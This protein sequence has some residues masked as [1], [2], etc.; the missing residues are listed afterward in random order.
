M[1]QR[2]Y[3]QLYRELRARLTSLG[4]DN[5]ENEARWLLEHI[6]GRPFL[7]LL[8]SEVDAAI[9]V[10]CDDMVRELAGG[11]PFQYV[12]GSQS[13]Y[14]LDL[15]VDERVLIPRRETEELVALALAWVAG[16]G[17]LRIL[18]LCTGSGAIAVALAKHLPSATVVAS[19]IAD[20]A[21]AVAAANAH[22]QQVAVQFYQGDLWTALPAGEAPFD[23]I[24]ANPPYLTREELV[25][26]GDTLA[27]EP[28]AALVGGDDGLRY[29]L[30]II[31][32]AAKHL[33]ASGLLLLEI[34][35]TQGSILLAAAAKEGF[36]S[37]VIVD[38]Q[39]KDRILQAE[40]VSIAVP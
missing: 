23:L 31:E 20:D 13:F 38:L 3:H 36:R 39:G 5:S 7:S 6:T 37:R 11:R 25:S 27:H 17:G 15:K 14:G 24:T 30:R 16:R 4:R 19:D 12:L 9:L 26:R 18:D 8:S 34:G 29:C 21:L 32:E 22:L 10:R 1:T 28:A 33:E 35:E 2:T 40:K